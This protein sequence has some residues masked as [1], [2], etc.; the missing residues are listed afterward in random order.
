MSIKQ[1]LRGHRNKS[2]LNKQ[3]QSATIVLTARLRLK[4]IRTVFKT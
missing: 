4:I 3:D 1:F 2:E